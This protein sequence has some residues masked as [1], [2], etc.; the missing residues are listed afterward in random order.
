MPLTALQ[1]GSL[2]HTSRFISEQGP[3]Q[4]APKTSK[5]GF[6]VERT[7]V[8]AE[9]RSDFQE[10][11]QSVSAVHVSA[12]PSFTHPVMQIARRAKQI[13]NMFF[14]TIVIRNFISAIRNISSLSSFETSF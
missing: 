10:T 1:T 9:W 11:L 5:T 13:M 3:H 6:L 12:V 8:K 14:C 2:G 7:S 4:V